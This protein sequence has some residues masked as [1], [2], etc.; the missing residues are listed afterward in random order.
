MTASLLLFFFSSRRRHTIFD[1]DWSSDVCSSDLLSLL[2]PLALVSQACRHDDATAPLSAEAVSDAGR[3]SAQLTFSVQPPPGVAANA[4]ISP[5]LQVTGTDAS[6]DAVRG[7][8][9]V[10]VEIGSRPPTGP[11]PSS[12]SRGKDEGG[13]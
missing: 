2:V 8:G 3:A 13:P 5:A 6:G 10:E 4:I 7:A 1:C 11:S 9:H 12:T